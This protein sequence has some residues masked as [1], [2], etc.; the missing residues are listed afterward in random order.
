[1]AIAGKQLDIVM[2][3]AGHDPVAVELDLVAPVTA[4]GL[5]DQGGQFRLEL[6]RQ[7]GFAGTGQ[8]RR[9]CLGRRRG[10]FFHRLGLGRGL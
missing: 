6:L 5:L 9:L 1:M 4:G 3:D 2:V 8:R 10:R 7:P